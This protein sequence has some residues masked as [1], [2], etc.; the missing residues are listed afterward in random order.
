MQLTTSCGIRI[1]FDG[2]HKV[3]AIIP[4]RF[5]RHLTGICG[6]CNGAPDDYRLSNGTDVTDSDVRFSLIGNSYLVPDDSDMPET[7]CNE[8]E[9][10]VLCNDEMEENV[11]NDDLCG[12]MLNPEGA[13][14]ECIAALAGEAEEFFYGC[15]YDICANQDLP[16]VVQTTV[17]QDLSALADMCGQS[18][19]RVTWRTSE[20]CRKS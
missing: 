16:N 3:I 15:K 13:F 18:G 7:E 5:Q 1:F 4:E 8:V 9:E 19:F 20:F 12:L 2:L 10:V 17:C 14:A 11:K 6:D